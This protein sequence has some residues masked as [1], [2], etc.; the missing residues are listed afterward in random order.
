[1]LVNAESASTESTK[2]EPVAA[3]II[4]D[5]N[6]DLNSF[7]AKAV[8]LTPAVPQIEGEEKDTNYFGREAIIKTFYEGPSSLCRCCIN[9]V[10][11]K[12]PQL[13]ETIAKSYDEAAIRLYK[14]KDHSSGSS[15]FSHL[16]ALSFHSIE[17]QSPFILAAIKQILEDSGTFLRDNQTAKFVR[18]F[19]E[20]YFAHSKIVHLQQQHNDQ[21]IT[22]KHLELL[23]K[24]M[25]ELF[26]VTATEV[27]GLLD[28]KLICFDHIWAIFPRGITVYSNADGHDRLYQTTGIVLLPATYQEPKRR[29]RIKCRYVQ[30]DGIDFGLSTTNHYITDFDG[31]QRISSL[32]VYPLGFHENPDLE[33][34]LME[35]GK[36]ILDFQEMGYHEYNG[37][38]IDGKSYEKYNVYYQF[39]I[40]SRIYTDVSLT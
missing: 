5:A 7:G 33:A 10:E 1:M 8:T 19:H 22:K 36:R 34:R 31:N 37:I 15:V 29:W 38:A 35:R 24:L 32:P 30:F 25:D 14:V 20:L 4:P 18:P 26:G 3:T 12:P 28:K 2:I 11:H 40:F 17:I 9:W 39:F 16:R 13:S 27:S 21:D 23:T 6:T